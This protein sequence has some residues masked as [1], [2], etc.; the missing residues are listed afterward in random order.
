MT[1]QET[2]LLITAAGGDSSFGRLLGL[3]E[4]AGWQQRINNWKRRG[5]PP[6]V[7]LAHQ[8][9]LQELQKQIPESLPV[10]RS[11]NAASAI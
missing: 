2:K 3:D 5:L 7:E 6:A 8:Q 11:A 10:R 4:K 1:P 9:Q